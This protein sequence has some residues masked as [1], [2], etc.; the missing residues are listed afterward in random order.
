MII[1]L[2]LLIYISSCK[3]T[4]SVQGI[5]INKTE[6]LNEIKFCYDYVTDNICVP[7]YSVILYN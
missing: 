4:D 6:I 7:Y 1:Y 5:C 2:L 3:I